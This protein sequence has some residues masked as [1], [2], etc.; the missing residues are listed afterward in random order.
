MNHD[1]PVIDDHP[2]GVRST[3]EAALLFVLHASFFNHPVCQ[4]IQHPIAGGGTNNEVIAERDYPLK[5]EQDDILCF[6]VFQG[7]DNCVC[8]FQGIQ[9]P[10]LFNLKIVKKQVDPA[11]ISSAGCIKLYKPSR[12]GAGRT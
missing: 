11:M 9:K 8:K 4:G 2:A 5:I 3:F 7:V 12:P 6:F 10:P 1:I